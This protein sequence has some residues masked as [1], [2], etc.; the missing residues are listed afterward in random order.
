MNKIVFLDAR[1]QTAKVEP[2]IRG[3]V[4][5]ECL[6]PQGFTLGHFPQSF[7]FSTV[8]GWIATRCVGQFSARYGRI[9]DVVV[10]LNVETPAGEIEIKGVPG[11]AAAP[12]IRDIL[13]GPAGCLRI[14]TLSEMRMHRRPEAVTNN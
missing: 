11:R 9:E 14:L 3:P 10:G 2:G 1:S 4:L 13:I 6:R 8:G 7:E 12:E 5:E